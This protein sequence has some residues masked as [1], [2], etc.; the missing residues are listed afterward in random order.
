M[1][2]DIE[3]TDLI[4]WLLTG[5]MIIITCIWYLFNAL[6]DKTIKALTSWVNSVIMKHKKILKDKTLDWEVRKE[7]IRELLKTQ[8]T[9]ENKN[10]D[11][12]LAI[13]DYVIQEYELFCID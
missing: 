5:I 1:L 7:K 11:K 6:K 12:A 4:S 10:T 13:L 2:N 9:L 3:I 8:A